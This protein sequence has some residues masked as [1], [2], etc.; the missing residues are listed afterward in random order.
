MPVSVSVSRASSRERSPRPRTIGSPTRQ[1]ALPCEL[2]RSAAP[3]SPE[4]EHLGQ[5]DLAFVLVVD[6]LRRRVC[7]GPSAIRAVRDPHHPRPA[8]PR[9]VE[10][11]QVHHAELASELEVRPETTRRGPRVLDD[12]P[13]L[14]CDVDQTLPPGFPP[15][16]TAAHSSRPSRTPSGSRRPVSR[17]R[18]SSMSSLASRSMPGRRRSVEHPPERAFAEILERQRGAADI[19]GEA[20]RCRLQACWPSRRG[21]E[22]NLGDLGKGRLRPRARTSAA[23]RA[24]PPPRSGRRLA[25]RGGGDRFGADPPVRVPPDATPSGLR[26]TPP[27]GTRGDRHDPTGRRRAR[28]TPD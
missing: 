7:D 15:S 3:R 5:L 17:A 28:R 26:R 8:N 2:A 6:D 4:S 24:A 10:H 16:A 22:Q 12:L 19:R 18:H 9:F 21:G 27:P 14:V 13:R 11:D 1:S 25:D 20:H 23:P